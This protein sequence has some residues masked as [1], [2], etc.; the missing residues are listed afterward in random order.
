LKDAGWR[1]LR[2]WNADILKNM[3]AVIETIAA[4]LDPRRQ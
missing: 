1:I 4:A 3:P 2:F